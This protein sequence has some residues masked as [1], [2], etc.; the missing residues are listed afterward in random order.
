MRELET[1][2][3]YGEIAQCK[4]EGRINSITQ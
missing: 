2:R 1:L 3:V 4:R